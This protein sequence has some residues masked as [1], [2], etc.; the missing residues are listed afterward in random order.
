MYEYILK[1]DFKF[2]VGSASVL[3]LIVIFTLVA[4]WYADLYK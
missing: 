4:I 2:Q 3:L 1:G